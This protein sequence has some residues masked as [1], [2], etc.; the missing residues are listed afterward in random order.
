MTTI[1]QDV[2]A[3]TLTAS[4]KAAS[5]AAG[6]DL[7]TLMAQLLVHVGEK[8]R[9]LKQILAFHPSTGGDAANWAAINAILAKL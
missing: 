2:T 8:Q 9:L 1:T 5:L 3:I 7:P 4:A 6:A